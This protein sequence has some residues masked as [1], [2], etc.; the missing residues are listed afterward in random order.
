LVELRVV[1]TA[2]VRLHEEFGIG[3]RCLSGCK[4]LKRLPVPQFCPRSELW[5][6]RIEVTGHLDQ[7]VAGRNVS[8]ERPGVRGDNGME[9]APSPTPV[10]RGIFQFIRRPVSQSEVIVTGQRRDLVMV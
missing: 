5:V 1:V 4:I 8:G 2:V 6:I 9:N 10:Y 3:I 7:G